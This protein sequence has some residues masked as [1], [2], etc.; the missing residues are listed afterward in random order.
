M[1]SLS[2][3]MMSLVIFAIYVIF[4]TSTSTFIKIITG[5]NAVAGFFLLGGYLATAY[6]QYNAYKSMMGLYDNKKEVKKC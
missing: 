2:V 5:I 4:F 3:L 6:V 1:L